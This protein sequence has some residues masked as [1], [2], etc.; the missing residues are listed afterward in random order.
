ME[1]TQKKKRSDFV[2]WLALIV[3]IVFGIM[4]HPMII[5][6]VAAFVGLWYYFK[7]S[8]PKSADIDEKEEVV[9]EKEPDFTVAGE[10]TDSFYSGISESSSIDKKGDKL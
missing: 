7:S 1:D 5:F 8:S 6:G 10:K 2:C 9:E 4:K 3:L